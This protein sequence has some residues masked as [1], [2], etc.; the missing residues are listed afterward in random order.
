MRSYEFVRISH[1]V[2]YVR[3]AVRSAWVFP[4]L[5]LIPVMSEFDQ[6]VLPKLLSLPA[7]LEFP[8][9]SIPPSSPWPFAGFPVKP[10]PPWSVP[11]APPWPPTRTPELPGSTLPP[12]LDRAVHRGVASPPIAPA[13]S[14]QLLLR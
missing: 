12:L 11:P 9:W 1:L 13:Q 4:F 5:T 14:V 7:P 6:P 8:V 2:K 10:E 3:I